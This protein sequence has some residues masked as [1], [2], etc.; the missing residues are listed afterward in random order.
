MVHLTKICQLMINIL[1]Y[2]SNKKKYFRTWTFLIFVYFFLHGLLPSLH[3][4]KLIM[5]NTVNGKRNT[6]Q[7]QYIHQFLHACFF[8][9]ILK[10]N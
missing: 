6:T 8:M 5:S 4:V 10:V 3:L 9:Q 2:T 7:K 1:P